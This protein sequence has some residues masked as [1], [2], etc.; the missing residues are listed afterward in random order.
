M[1]YTYEL[2]EDVKSS[3][4]IIMEAAQF[5]L[6]TEDMDSPPTDKI[7]LVCICVLSLELQIAEL[8]EQWSKVLPTLRAVDPPS[9]LVGGGDSENSAGN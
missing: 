1:T 3:A 6:A 9:A 8:R 2:N 4:G 7:D 5:I